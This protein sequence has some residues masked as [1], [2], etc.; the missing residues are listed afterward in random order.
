MWCTHSHHSKGPLKP[1]GWHALNSMQ[2]APSRVLNSHA[3]AK[4][5]VG[6]TGLWGWNWDRFLHCAGRSTAC[7]LHA[8]LPA[9]LKMSLFLRKKPG[10]MSTLL[11]TPTCQLGQAIPNSPRGIA[12]VITPLRNHSKSL[13]IHR[14]EPLLQARSLPMRLTPLASKL[15][16]S[17]L[18]TCGS[19]MCALRF[20]RRNS[21]KSQPQLNIFF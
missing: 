10:F 3:F 13:H 15:V 2:K 19:W 7:L 20:N 1:T 4:F 18:S 16:I 17:C 8:R 21:L 9:C 14:R 5:A 11:S 12:A 6:G